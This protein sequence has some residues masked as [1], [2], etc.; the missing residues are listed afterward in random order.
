MFCQGVDHLG[1]YYSEY[2]IP[3]MFTYYN[4]LICCVMPGTKL[5]SGAL[6]SFLALWAAGHA[7]GPPVHHGGRAPYSWRVL[8]ALKVAKSGNKPRDCFPTSYY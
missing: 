2:L 4:K 6:R 8:W 5:F 7:G 3:G 1:I